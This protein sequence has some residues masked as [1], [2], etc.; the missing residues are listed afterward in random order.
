MNRTTSEKCCYL[1]LSPLTL[2]TATKMKGLAVCIT[3]GV[4]SLL[5]EPGMG[6][7]AREMMD[8]R[9]K[10]N[11]MC[12]GSKNTTRCENTCGSAIRNRLEM[13]PG[14]PANA[15]DAIV[16]QSRPVINDNNRPRGGG[17]GDPIKRRRV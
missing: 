5:L 17:H 15:R 3:I 1:P 11:G 9:I 8:I 6:V 12:A 13:H 4:I 2:T 10:C 14:A 16:K 7:T